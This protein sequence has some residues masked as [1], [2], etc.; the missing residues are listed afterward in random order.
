MTPWLRISRLAGALRAFGVSDAERW[1]ELL[2]LL[3]RNEGG[4]GDVMV[5]NELVSSHAP[6][7]QVDALLQKTRTLVPP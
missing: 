2:N 4:R 3:R 1:E 6:I 7:A 5:R